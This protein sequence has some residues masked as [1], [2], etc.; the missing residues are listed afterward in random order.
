MGFYGIKFGLIRPSQTV[1]YGC[2]RS[3]VKYWIVT[4]FCLM[5]A[6]HSSMGGVWHCFSHIKKQYKSP[7]LLVKSS[8]SYGFPMVFP[9][10]FSQSTVDFFMSNTESL[11]SSDFHP[12]LAPKSWRNRRTVTK[13]S[14]GLIHPHVILILSCYFFPNVWLRKNM[15][16]TIVKIPFRNISP[17]RIWDIPRNAER[18]MSSC[19][20][21]FWKEKVLGR[22]WKD[23]H[24][25]DCNYLKVGGPGLPQGFFFCPSRLFFFRQYMQHF[26]TTSTVIAAFWS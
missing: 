13:V 26:G 18:K 7:L 10:C 24:S 6:H 14:I 8:F 25:L 2:W 15:I 1:K 23:W 9:I 21:V 3:A 12:F 20:V 5:W 17:F 22:S 16:A 11:T 19:T 4:V